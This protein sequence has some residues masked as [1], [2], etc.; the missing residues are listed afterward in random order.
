MLHFGK[1]FIGSER[2]R[3]VVV[4][5]LLI[6]SIPPFS[7]S[8][9]FV[10]FQPPLQATPLFSILLEYWCERVHSFGFKQGVYSRRCILFAHGAKR[11]LTFVFLLFFANL[12]GI[13]H[14][15]VL[16]WD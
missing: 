11:F 15:P 1:C 7:P 2:E 9:P 8:F 12:S 6:Q 14:L 16:H 13:N 5:L 4:V 10:S 3:S